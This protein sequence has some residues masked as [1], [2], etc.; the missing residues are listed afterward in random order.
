LGGKMEGEKPLVFD[1][2]G[3]PTEVCGVSISPKL[4]KL[5]DIMRREK[6]HGGKR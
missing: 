5:I 1:P 3:R 2:N 6:G 4:A